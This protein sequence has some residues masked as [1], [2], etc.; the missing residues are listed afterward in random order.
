MIVATR[1]LAPGLCAIC[2]KAKAAAPGACQLNRL[3]RCRSPYWQVKLAVP[4]MVVEVFCIPLLMVNCKFSGALAVIVIVPG[5]E[6]VTSPVDPM[7]A[8]TDPEGVG[9]VFQERPSACESSRLL[10]LAKL[11]VAV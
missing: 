2:N 9:D 7:V 11:P 8:A 1:F 5:A 6:Q 10:P 4:L 3:P